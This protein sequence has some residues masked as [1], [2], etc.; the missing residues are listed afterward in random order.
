MAF[1]S[2]VMAR[3][4]VEWINLHIGGPKMD[5]DLLILIGSPFQEERIIFPFVL[6]GRINMILTYIMIATLYF[7]VCSQRFIVCR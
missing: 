1:F 2:G 6:P 3:R 5:G 4:A 7:I